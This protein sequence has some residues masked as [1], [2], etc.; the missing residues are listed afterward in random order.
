MIVLSPR[1]YVCDAGDMRQRCLPLRTCL[2][3]RPSCIAPSTTLRLEA[4][5]FFST[6]LDRPR[7]NPRGKAEAPMVPAYHL[8][9][10]PCMSHKPRPLHELDVGSRLELGGAVWVMKSIK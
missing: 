3:P 6:T 4:G 2:W 1:A 8:L 5:P 7:L 9:E 10:I